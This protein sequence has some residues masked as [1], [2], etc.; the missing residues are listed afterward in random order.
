MTIRDVTCKSENGILIYGTDESIIEDVRLENIDLVL[1]D[2][3]LNDFAGGNIDLRGCL[4]MEQSIFSHDV[5]GLFAR[6]VKG[7]SIIDF[8]LEWKNINEPYF[9]NGI[10]AENYSDLEII[11]FTGSSAPGNSSAY[12]VSLIN[13]SGFRTDLDNKSVRIK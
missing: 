6:Y 4:S 12:P 3:K 9:T 7:L 8:T 10:E 2:S 1:A 13:G 11:N 5:P